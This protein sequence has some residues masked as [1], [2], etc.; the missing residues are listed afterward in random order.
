MSA[1][2]GAFLLWQLSRLDVE[3]RSA[4]NLGMLNLELAW[5]AERAQEVRDSWPTAGDPMLWELARRSLHLD[6]LFIPAYGLFYLGLAVLARRQLLARARRG[7]RWMIA[8]P[9]AA[10][11]L[12]VIENV[13]LLWILH[14]EGRPSAWVVALVSGAATLKFLLLLITSLPLLIIGIVRGRRF[15]Q[16][17][18]P[19]D[20]DPEN[21]ARPEQVFEREREYLKGRRAKV[22]DLD[23][24]FER[25]PQ[26]IGLSFSG[27]GIRSATVCL[28][29][30]QALCQRKILPK[31]DYL[32]TVSGGGY[33]GSALS[34]LLSIH[35][36]KLDRSSQG[37]EEQYDFSAGGGP[38]FSTEPERFPFAAGP[39]PELD[40]DFNGR[41]QVDH[42]RTHGDFLILRRSL[43]HRD[44]LRTVG[45]VLG[46][47]FYHL[48]LFVV[49][50]AT[51]A[52][53]YLA[54][55]HAMAGFVEVSGMAGEAAR[56]TLGSYWEQLLNP[57]R[58]AWHPFWFALALGSLYLPLAMLVTSKLVWG[59]TL[60]DHWFR[61]G[62]ESLEE[63]REYH[64]LWA[65]FYL[66]LLAAAAV[67]AFSV[68]AQGP[69]VSFILLPMGVYL[70]G[71]ISTLAL[72]AVVAIAPIFDRNSRSRFAAWKG[73]FDYLT[74]ASI[75]VILFPLVIRWLRQPEYTGIGGIGWLLSLAGTWLF[76]RG[77]SSETSAAKLQSWTAKLMALTGSVRRFLL[78]VVVTGVIVV[79][80]LW[81]CAVILRLEEQRR[82]M[83]LWSP[84]QVI[85]F[86]SIIGVVFLG[87]LLVLG[88]LLDF[89]K[90]S[91]HHFYRDRL[92]EAYLQ[93]VGPSKTRG[94]RHHRVEDALDTKRDNAEM[95][96]TRL[97]GSLEPIAKRS[98]QDSLAD[99]YQRIM[100]QTKKARAAQ[101]AAPPELAATSA[102]YHLLVTCLNM[103]RSRDLRLRNRRSDLFVFSKLY[104]GSHTT[105]YM[106]TRRYRG[107]ATKLAAAMTISGAAVSPAIGSGTFFA[108]A[109]ATSLFNVRLGQWIENPAYRNGASAHRRE[110]LVF[111]PYY[112]IKEMLGATDAGDRLVYLSD[113]GHTGDNLGIGP[114]LQR[115]CRLIVALDAECD[116][117]L[118]FGSLIQAIRL[119]SIDTDVERIE[120]DLEPIRPQPGSGRSQRH[121]AVGRIDYGAGQKG[122]LVLLK[123]SLTGDEDEPIK[124]YQRLYAVFPHQTT[125][126]QFFDDAQF[127][128][129]RDLGQHLATRAFEQ[130]LRA[131]LTERKWQR[132]WDSE[133]ERLE[134]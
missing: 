99:Y 52:A 42:L 71:W 80:F 134:A 68:Y 33:I 112:L 11:L 2:A 54:I 46:G 60:P 81:I 39:Q 58:R 86:R 74:I 59:R 129:Y 111:W 25:H 94:D 14:G 108:Q 67:T 32:S 22:P 63:N 1:A 117:E 45:A 65:L 93:T 118:G 29:A 48:L 91:L 84:T 8:F 15:I 49:L 114:L 27:G 9:V 51:L 131:A 56:D 132:E 83:D 53:L 19:G 28:G 57:L 35:K 50:I 92:V 95:P 88:I 43:I 121:V 130:E 82:G 85:G 24:D 17:R 55:L 7:W 106:D 64:S 21:F 126:D 73:I 116:P 38:Y 61:R 79:G 97:H 36:G 44:V 100:P 90:L 23:P 5:T 89:N 31:I 123:A 103:T 13:G 87:L 98:M 18:L 107:G 122:W 16:Q 12:D 30:V 75:I 104:C 125:A 3:L 78:G 119:A 37:D 34:S 128:S 77:G 41:V 6:F 105:G 72:H 69:Q 113:G 133:F 96:L 102:P 47:L 40:P 110:N 101:A 26:A 4:G 62:Q 70:G 76:S 10:M 115:R 120:I 20:A 124:G 127:E 66:T 109:F